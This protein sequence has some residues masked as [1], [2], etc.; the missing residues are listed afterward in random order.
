MLGLMLCCHKLEIRN[1]F[2]QGTL[3]LCTGLLKLCHQS[4]TCEI[5]LGAE[6]F[7]SLPL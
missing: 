3:P 2:E 5:E 4:C 6:F 1:D 7:V